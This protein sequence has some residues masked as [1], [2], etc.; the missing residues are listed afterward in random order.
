MEAEAE[1]PPPLTSP[2][3]QGFVKGGLRTLEHKVATDSLKR[4]KGVT[5]CHLALMLKSLIYTCK[6]NPL[7]REH[8]D[9]G[10]KPK[11]KKKPMK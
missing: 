7:R 9:E 4:L 3:P 1:S 8:G 6:K 10:N 2:H 5:R 11:K